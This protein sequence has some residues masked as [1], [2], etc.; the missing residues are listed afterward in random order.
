MITTTAEALAAS[1]PD[2]P[3][4]DLPE[5][6][7]V[8]DAL[9][10]AEAIHSTLAGS[11][12][13]IYDLGW[14]R[15]E[16]WCAT[17]D[18]QPLPASAA[19]VCAYLTDLAAAGA[20]V[21]TLDLAVGA[22]SYRHRVRGL[23]DPTACEAVRQVR[24]GLR[25]LVGTAPRRQ[26]RPL[27]IADLRQILHPI[28]RTTAKGA[29]DAAVILLG[30]ASALRVSELVG[31]TLADVE[32]KPAG[33]LLHIHRSKTDQEAAGH[34]VPVAH[35]QR[36]DTDPIAALGGWLHHRGTGPGPLF[37]ALRNRRVTADPLSGTAVGRMLRGR[38][39]DAGLPAERITPHSLRA[40]HA[41]AAALAGVSLDR[42]AAQTRHKRLSTLLE[43]YIRPAQALEFTSSRDL[44]L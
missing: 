9:R 41:T 13:R 8:D 23:D 38:A 6:L 21:P 30:F 29:R 22:I 14:K 16:R 19:L 33:L 1:L 12:R 4:L 37:T 35:G 28:D 3:A 40:G 7:T 34:L 31:L 25:R 44:G 2:S 36:A 24:R 39:T 42:I 11:T 20:S 5:G 18:A 15:W 32:H 10:I 26:A 43:R 27:D 17:R